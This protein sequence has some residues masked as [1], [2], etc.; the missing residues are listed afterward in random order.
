MLKIRGTEVL[1][2]Y[3][4]PVTGIF[5][6]FLFFFLVVVLCFVLFCFFFKYEK[7]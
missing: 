5:V 7:Y 4:L 1:Q 2:Y 6:L 3:F